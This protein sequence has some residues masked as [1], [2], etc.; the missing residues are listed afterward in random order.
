MRPHQ[1]PGR[2]VILQKD[3][4]LELLQ[5]FTRVAVAFL[6][7]ALLIAGTVV[8]TPQAAGV[9]GW[10]ITWRG[11]GPWRGTPVTAK[12]AKGGGPRTRVQTAL[13]RLSP[14]LSPTP[15]NTTLL[16]AT[17]RYTGRVPS[18]SQLAEK[19]SYAVG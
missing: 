19:V 11:R 18:I 17:R 4:M 13:K 1:E 16:A 7:R 2:V 8:S 15:R 6:S 3:A 10:Q 12:K 14:R 9:R 5:T